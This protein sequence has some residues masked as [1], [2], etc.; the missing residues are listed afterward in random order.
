MNEMIKIRQK[1]GEYGWDIYQRF[2]WLKVKLKY[3]MTAMQRKHIFV[4]SL[5]PH[6]K[7]PLRQQNFQTQAE[8]LQE[9]LQLEENQYQNKNLSIEEIK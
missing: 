7:Y 3:V 4:N 9:S 1:P 5:L 6:L 8:D 2:K